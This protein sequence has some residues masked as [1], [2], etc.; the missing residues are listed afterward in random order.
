VVVEGGVEDKIAAL[1]N[2]LN[3]SFEIPKTAVLGTR[4]S[5]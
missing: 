3:G 4:S 2:A 1:A 5:K